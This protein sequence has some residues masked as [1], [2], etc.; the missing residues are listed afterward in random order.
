MHGST[1]LKINDTILNFNSIN[2]GFLALNI[3][4]L[5]DTV[6]FRG[7]FHNESKFVEFIMYEIDM[8]N[9]KV[10]QNNKEIKKYNQFNNNVHFTLLGRK[11]NK[12][13]NK[14]LNPVTR[15]VPLESVQVRK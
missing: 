12:T 15:Q 8:E 7:S 10:T 1:S 4:M 3:K 5:N 14:A 13:A 2:E 11:I 9:V 6:V